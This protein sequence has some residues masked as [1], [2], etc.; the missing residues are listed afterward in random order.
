[1]DETKRAKHCAA[2]KKYRDSH[3]EELMAKQLARRRAVK[4]PVFE[5][6]HELKSMGYTSLQVSQQLGM[7]L[8]IT[9]KFYANSIPIHD[10]KSYWKNGCIYENN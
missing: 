9:N 2:Q 6:V 5:K 1:M 10:P 3:H 7:P 4:I 8:N